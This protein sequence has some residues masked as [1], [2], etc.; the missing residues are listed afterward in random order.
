MA[1]PCVRLL[2]YRVAI[3]KRRMH[4]EAIR[5]ALTGRKLSILRCKQSGNRYVIPS[6]PTP[7]AEWI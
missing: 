6:G 4:P 3:Q 2:A 7:D 5:F 1:F